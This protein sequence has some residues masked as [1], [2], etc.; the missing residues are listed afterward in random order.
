MH[1]ESRGILYLYVLAIGGMLIAGSGCSFVKIPQGWIMRT[2]W[3]L[4]FHRMPFYAGCADTCEPT[5]DAPPTCNVQPSCNINSRPG[6]KTTVAPGCNSNAP[7]VQNQP[8][9]PTKPARAPEPTLAPEKNVCKCPR[10]C[11]SPLMDLLQRKGRLGICETCG[12]ITRMQDTSVQP[13]VQATMPVV[14]KFHPVPTAPA[15]CPQPNPTKPVGFESPVDKKKA[16]PHNNTNKPAPVKKTPPAPKPQPQLQKAKVSPFKPE[17]VPPPPAP[18]ESSKSS[19]KTPREFELPAEP[20]EWVFTNS[21]AKVEEPQ[22]TKPATKIRAV[23]P[24]KR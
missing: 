1:R 5:C 8:S 10:E 20:P 23:Q 16:V 9:A 19:E 2:G 12:K 18:M 21:Q 24:L 22:V 17:E 15:F 11:D 7:K 4:E 14:A 6:C 3:S 13:A